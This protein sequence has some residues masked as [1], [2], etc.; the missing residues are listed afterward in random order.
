MNKITKIKKFVTGSTIGMVVAG[1]LVAG[2]A[3]AALL[4]VYTTMLGEGD[5]EQSVKFGN[6]DIAK[7]YTIGN[8][9]AIAGNTYTQNYNLEN[10]SETTA[11]IRFVTNQCIVGGG[12]CG[13]TYHDE[14]G[15][16]TS[17]WSTLELTQKDKNWDPDP[18]GATGTLTYELV[19]SKFNYEF[20]AEGLDEGGEYS[21]IYYADKQ[22]RFENF[23]GDNPGA[24]IAEFTADDKGNISAEGSKNLGMD[25]PHPEDWNGS[26]EANYCDNEEDDDYELCRGAKIWLVPTNDYNGT[27]KVVDWNNMDS[28][29]YETDLITYDDIDNGE[30]LYLGEG[31]L[32]FFVKNV[33]DIALAPGDYEVSTKIKPVTN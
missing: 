5:V 8:S 32:N 26:S 25:L 16:E 17:Y 12:Y 2:V 18:K 9:P 3:S 21:L 13:A 1:L 14:P 6:G 11:P 27:D 20:E 29:L 30:A 22:D 33:L 28:Y 31:I 7:T 19:A 15:V 24:L 10:S 4:T 23:G